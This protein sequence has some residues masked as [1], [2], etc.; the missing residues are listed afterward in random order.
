MDTTK[1]VAEV[2]EQIQQLRNAM[3]LKLGE[4]REIEQEIISMKKHLVVLRKEFGDGMA[5]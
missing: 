4:V 3:L 2:E 1:H 5:E